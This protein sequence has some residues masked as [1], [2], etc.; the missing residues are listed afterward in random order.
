MRRWPYIWNPPLDHAEF[1]IQCSQH[2][3]LL[4]DQQDWK[5]HNLF[6]RN[7]HQT[8]PGK[9]KEIHLQGSFSHWPMFSLFHCWIM[10]ILGYVV[11]L[12]VA[13]ILNGG[14]RTL[15]LRQGF[16]CVEQ[17]LIHFQV[18]SVLFRSREIQPLDHF[19]FEIYCA[20]LYGIQS[21]RWV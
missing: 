5:K 16:V 14:D 12:E 18:S 7:H 6:D 1:W 21:A 13:F 19:D 17:Q 4:T 10:L 3:P 15:I 9:Q 2:N 20:K 11:R 8:F